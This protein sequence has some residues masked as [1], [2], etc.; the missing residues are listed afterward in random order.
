MGFLPGRVT[1]VIDKGGIVRY[2][3]SSQ[4][5]VT[6]HV[7]EALESLVAISKAR[8]QADDRA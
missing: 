4:L 3:F 6:R 8:G 5:Q 7:Q 2:I 1:Y